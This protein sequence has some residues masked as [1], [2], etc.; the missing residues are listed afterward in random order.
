MSMKRYGVPRT[1]ITEKGL[2][3]LIREAAK[4]HSSVGDWGTENKIT[5]QA[6]SAFFRK[7]QGAGIK[8]PHVLGYRPQVIYLPLDEELIQEPPA[9]RR[10]TANLTSKV[11][12]HKPPIEKGD[13]NKQVERESVK[14]KLKSRKK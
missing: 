5:P 1:A 2:K 9:P 13:K 10:L 3:K 4:E 7:T 14:A 8:I 12:P 6:I 11:D